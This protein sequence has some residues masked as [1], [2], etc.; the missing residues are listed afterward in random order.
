MSGAAAKLMWAKYQEEN[1]FPRAA[2]MPRFSFSQTGIN[3]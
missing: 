2:E 3:G 1:R